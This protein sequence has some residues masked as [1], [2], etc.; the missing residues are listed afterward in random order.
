MN[1]PR[2]KDLDTAI[3]AARLD[4]RPILKEEEGG[5]RRTGYDRE[6]R[7][8][9]YARTE[10]VMEEADRLLRE[11]ELALEWEGTDVND[12]GMV[13]TRWALVHVPTG[14]RKPYRWTAPIAPVE[15]E[16]LGV[17][18]TTRH[19]QRWVTLLVLQIPLLEEPRPGDVVDR[20]FVVRR[21]ASPAEVE[22][23]ELDNLVGQA[24]DW[25]EGGG[26]LVD[27][28]SLGGEDPMIDERLASEADAAALGQVVEAPSL[29]AIHRASTKWRGKHARTMAD[30]LAAAGVT[31]FKTEADRVALR[32]FLE[33]EECWT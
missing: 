25:M 32:G 18:W 31:G 8:W 23:V 1:A 16:T 22:R 30:L 27:A 6:E 7:H 3:R 29:D 13:V 21:A 19:A 26:G 17:A 24:P 15:N 20:G 12:R 28:G 4:A 14:Q 11:H 10:R 5:K 9:Y 2:H 33:R